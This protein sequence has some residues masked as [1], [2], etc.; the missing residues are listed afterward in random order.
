MKIK[1]VVTTLGVDKKGIIA[2]IAHILYE[3][4][5]NILDISQTIIEDNFNMMMVVEMDSEQLEPLSKE[6][7]TASR[8]MQVTTV[9]QREDIFQAMHRL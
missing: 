7:E 2:K 1:V 6:L 4:D 3:N 5:V 9:L 8:A